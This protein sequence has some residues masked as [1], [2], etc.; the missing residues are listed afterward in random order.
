MARTTVRGRRLN[1]NTSVAGPPELASVAIDDKRA[2]ARFGGRDAESGEPVE[3]VRTRRATSP[4]EPRRR[5]RAPGPRRRNRPDQQCGDR[6]IRE[7]LDRRRASIAMVEA[8]R[9]PHREVARC[10]TASERDE[11][12]GEHD[13]LRCER[14]KRTIARTATTQ[15]GTGVFASSPARPCIARS[16]V[17][18]PPNQSR[19]SSAPTRMRRRRRMLRT[20][21]TGA[22]RPA[23]SCQRAGGARCLRSR[24]PR[25]RA[26]RR[27][28]GSSTIKRY[29]RLLCMLVVDRKRLC[30]TTPNVARVARRV[31]NPAV[32]AS[33]AAMPNHSSA[34]ARLAAARGTTRRTGGG[35]HVAI[36][37]AV[38]RI[39]EERSEMHEGDDADPA[40]QHGQRPHADP[41]SEGSVDPFPGHDARSR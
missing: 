3:R 34:T 29:A 33:A 36:D 22:A 31:H 24:R 1:T 27:R 10:R 7:H 40:A 17:T 19:S 26:P 25:T 37:E 6:E 11:D 13:H 15:S 35:T 38:A 21:A 16:H 20:A 12:L 4:E 5:R 41:M 18:V 28:R 14:V 30:A 23:R 9:D 2:G 32:M 8:H 39:I